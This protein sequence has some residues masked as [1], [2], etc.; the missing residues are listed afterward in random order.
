MRVYK[1]T[2]IVFDF[3]EVGDDIP[4]TLEDARFPNRCIS[5]EVTECEY[6]EIGAWHDDHPL[7]KRDTHKRELEK[8]FKGE[9]VVVDLKK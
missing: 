5:P 9:V 6:A 7:N 3:D 8:I 4:T 2:V 1:M